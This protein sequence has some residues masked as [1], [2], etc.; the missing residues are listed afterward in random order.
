MEGVRLPD[1]LLDLGDLTE[2]WAVAELAV[3]VSSLLH[4]DGVGPA[5]VLPAVAAFAAQRPLSDAEIEALWPLVV[6][7]GAVLVVS[8]HQ[9][10]T[11]DGENDYAAGNMAH[12][13]RILEVACSVPVPVMTALLR[14]RLGRPLPALQLPAGAGLLVDDQWPDVLDLSA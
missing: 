2:S 14:A 10:V 1:G 6:L 13:Q 9:Q 12:E 7:R 4:H 3:T 8:G 5:A 11:L